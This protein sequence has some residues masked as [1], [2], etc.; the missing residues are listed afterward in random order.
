MWPNEILSD[1][2][3]PLESGLMKLEL[4]DL[5][6]NKWS[7]EV[8]STATVA[9]VKELNAEIRGLSENSQQK[10]IYSGKILKDTD[11]VESLNYNEGK[12]Y[13]VCMVSKSKVKPKSAP[14][15]APAPAPEAPVAGTTPTPA[16]ESAAPRTGPSSEPSQPQGG[17]S[18]PAVPA[19]FNDPSAFATGSQLDATVANIMELG[20]PRGQVLLAMRR[21]FNNP[22]R[23]VEYL[24][25]GDIPEVS[26]EPESV[27]EPTTEPSPRE[28]SVQAPTGQEDTTDVNL[29]DV[30]AAGEEQEPDFQQLLNLDDQ[31]VEQ[32]RQL[33]AENPRHIASIIEP[34][35]QQNP[36][37]GE[38][39]TQ[40]LEA[41]LRWI[42]SRSLL[43]GDDIDADDLLSD[44]GAEH[45]SLPEQV[46]Q[47]TPE[48]NEAIS[49]LVELG[50]DRS[51]VIQAY[52]A[53][54]KNEE[55]TANYLFEHGDEE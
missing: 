6:H 43:S 20:Y 47:I 3:T 40:N 51:L 7:I 16:P 46:I 19:A 42:A 4:H 49:R 28:S 25:N 48:E 24:L 38:V 21:A 31:Q 26:E 22:D 30:A 5:K 8:E 53:C 29:F 14:A 54:D 17:A 23:A 2:I 11:V 55:I 39:I 33:S 27:P 37:V 1:I 36:Q 34:L 18:A 44:S 12:D 45:G 50:F 35:I 10:L 15:P 13:I 9:H 52:F 32:L 41:F